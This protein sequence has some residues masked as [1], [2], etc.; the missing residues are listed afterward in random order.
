M[1]LSVLDLRCIG[2]DGPAALGPSV[3]SKAFK[4]LDDDIDSMEWRVG[5]CRSVGERDSEVRAC[6]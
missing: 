6:S 3:A 5:D 2:R 1:L 4:E